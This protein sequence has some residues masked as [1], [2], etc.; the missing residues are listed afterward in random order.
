MHREVP[1]YV[2]IRQTAARNSTAVSD[3]ETHFA[4]GGRE[5]GT[6]SI[7][8]TDLVIIRIKAVI[9]QIIVILLQCPAAVAV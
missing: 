4:L 1:V 9:E 5:F 7:N 8:N 2:K 3:T 6:M